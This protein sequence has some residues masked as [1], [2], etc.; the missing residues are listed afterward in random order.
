MGLF[1]VPSSVA[2]YDNNATERRM[3]DNLKPI[4]MH[5]KFF[6]PMD[7]TTRMLKERCERWVSEYNYTE[8]GEKIP[9]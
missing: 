9:E 3:A 2:I 5:A 8:C 4:I 7:Y 6:R 1:N